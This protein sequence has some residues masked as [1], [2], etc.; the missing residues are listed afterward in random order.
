MGPIGQLPKLCKR[1][2]RRRFVI[3][4]VLVA[5][6]LALFALAACEDSTP[7]PI[8]TPTPSCTPA[9]TAYLDELDGGLRSI[10]AQM[11][12]LGEDWADA[13]AN[14]LLLLDEVWVLGQ[15]TAL[16]TLTLH[17]DR[18]IALTQPA[19]AQELDELVEAT[20]KQSKEAL[21]LLSGGLTKADADLMLQGTALMASASD[22]ARYV[23]VDM[24]AFCSSSRKPS[25]IPTRTPTQTPTPRPTATPM[26]APMA[27]PTPTPEPAPTPTPEPAPTP[28]PEPA[29]TPTPE[30]TP[31]PTLS[32]M[33][34]CVAH[35]QA[36]IKAD[37][38]IH[39]A[40]E[41]LYAEGLCLGQRTGME[42][43]V[44]DLT[45]WM[46][47][48]ARAYRVGPLQT[49]TGFIVE[50]E[51]LAEGI[52]HARMDFRQRCEGDAGS[53]YVIGVRD[54]YIYAERSAR[55]AR[56]RRSG[57]CPVRCTATA[58]LATC[59]GADDYGL[60]WEPD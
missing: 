19:S 40:D 9:E 44:D 20:M 22:S 36:E 13:S 24:A 42:R 46:N 18:M 31:T 14:P 29:P 51:V 54:Y 57:T 16:T 6:V 4:K 28:T 11:G 56:R 2:G 45:L 5:V 48:F 35:Q 12:M 49:Y 34:K 1:T 59:A 50:P 30:P 33:D 25:P 39:V 47:D 58:R 52:A 53:G 38:D 26:P 15:E 21:E 27:A 41:R 55:T 17:V 7:T 8:P 10:G 32:W 37:S 43:E 3:P 23:R 60:R